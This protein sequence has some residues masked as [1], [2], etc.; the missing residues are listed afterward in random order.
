MTSR[1]VNYRT[2]PVAG[3]LSKY[4]LVKSN[5]SGQWAAAGVGEVPEAIVSVQADATM[6]TLGFNAAG[7]LLQFG[8]TEFMI[9]DVAIALGEAVY[10]AAAGRVT[11]LVTGTKVGICRLAATAQNDI[12]EVELQPDLNLW[13]AKIVGPSTSIAGTAAE[14]AYDKTVTIGANVL[15]KGVRGRIRAK[16]LASVTTG[17]ETLLFKLKIFDGTNTIVLGAT[18]AVDVANGDQ[19]VIDIEFELPTA[20]TLLASGIAG[21]GQATGSLQATGI[22]SSTFDPT[23]AATVSVTQTASSTGETSALSS[24][25]VEI[26]R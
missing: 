19:G 16:V 21:I 15:R 8:R 6:A 18:S 7:Y 9:A 25:S 11:N 4:A 22:G 10:P 24:L 1:N 26:H 3:A 13:N 5:A 23:A 12:V 14:T 2:L 17:A 20:T